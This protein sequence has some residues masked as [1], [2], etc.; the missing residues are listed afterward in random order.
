MLEIKVLE[1]NAKKAELLSR[2]QKK[3][4]EIMA[5]F[6]KGEIIA[7]TVFSLLE[8]SAVIEHIVPEEDIMMADGMLRSTIH[9]ALCRGKGEV[10]YADTVSEK[11]LDTLK[12]VKDKDKKLL[13]HEKL[14]GSCCCNK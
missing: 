13:D 14:F 9:V 7:Y 3:Q 2:F 8:K 4:G 11:L 1:D 6:D 5:A 10:F 12:F